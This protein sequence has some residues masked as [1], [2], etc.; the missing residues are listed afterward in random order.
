MR[1]SP[2]RPGRASF[3]LGLARVVPRLPEHLVV[4]RPRLVEPALAVEL[5]GEGAAGRGVVGVGLDQ[6]PAG[7]PRLPRSARSNR[8]DASS[9][10]VA[11]FSGR[12]RASSRASSSA[13]VNRPGAREVEHDALGDRGVR[14]VAPLELAQDLERLVE[15]VLLLVEVDEGRG[16]LAVAGVGVV[17]RAVDPLGLARAAGLA[18]WPRRSA[19]GSSAGWRAPEARPGP[20]RLRPHGRPRAARGRGSPRCRCPRA[21][22]AARP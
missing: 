1:G 10:R 17:E 2:A 7:S 12:R 20:R 9:R 5:G 3:G 22:A 13:S 21:R 18:P 4:H 8:T 16:D 11:R 6:G 15:L 19:A 14:R